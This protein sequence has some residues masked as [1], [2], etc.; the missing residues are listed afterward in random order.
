MSPAQES[1]VPLQFSDPVVGAALVAGLFGLA[2][3][4]VNGIVQ[5]IC[6]WLQNRSRKPPSRRPK[7]KPKPRKKR[8]RPS[9]LA[10]PPP[11]HDVPVRPDCPIMP[12]DVVGDQLAE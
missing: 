10:R 8:R 5:I 2:V 1:V 11:Q 12:L 9:A 7:P 3:A 4:V 6:T